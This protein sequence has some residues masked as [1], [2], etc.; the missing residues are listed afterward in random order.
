MRDHIRR[1]A[2]QYADAVWWLVPVAFAAAALAAV[3]FSEGEGAQDSLHAAVVQPAP[4]PAAT[5][6]SATPAPQPA[7]PA[8]EVTEHVQAF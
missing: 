1:E 8:Y 6:V 4:Q 2:T 5:P 7:E 3:A